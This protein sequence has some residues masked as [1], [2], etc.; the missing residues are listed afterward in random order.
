MLAWFKFLWDHEWPSCFTLGIEQWRVFLVCV[1]TLMNKNRF[2]SAPSSCKIF[3]NFMFSSWRTFQEVWANN[4]ILYLNN[5][6]CWNITHKKPYQSN[7]YFGIPI[8]LSDPDYLHTDCFLAQLFGC[9]IIF[10][11][12][13]PEPCVQ[14]TWPTDTSKHLYFNENY[15]ISVAKISRKVFQSFIKVQ[16]IQISNV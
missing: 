11:Q 16:I 14:T 6:I 8:H 3:W 9:W 5:F 10:R 13:F 2:V 1:Q 12:H 15:Y 4:H 7:V